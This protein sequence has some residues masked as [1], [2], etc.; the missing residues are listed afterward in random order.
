M[1]R[2]RR[3]APSRMGSASAAT[4]GQNL[5]DRRNG[6][7]R[8]RCRRRTWRSCG[9]IQAF[10]QR[11]DSKPPSNSAIPEVEWSTRTTPWSR[12]PGAAREAVVDAAREACV[13]A[14]TTSSSRSRISSMRATRWSS[15]QTMHGARA[16]AA[17]SRSNTRDRAMS[18]P[19]A[20][21]KAVRVTS[22]QRPQPRPSKP[23]GLSE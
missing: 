17:A 18:G 19:F 12:A 16:E 13:E 21:G 11:G 10:G 1:E 3:A 15:S 23:S 20:N 5:S 22:V 9:A 14:S 6:I 7:L 8:G 2:Y 4:R